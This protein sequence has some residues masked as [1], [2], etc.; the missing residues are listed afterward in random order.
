MKARLVHLNLAT[1]SGDPRMFWLIAS[2][3]KKQNWDVSVACAYFDEKVFPDLRGDIRVSV[4][5]SGKI[6]YYSSG[7]NIYR[8][9]WSRV[10]RKMLSIWHVFLISKQSFDGID[11]LV[12]QN[13]D[14]YILGKI[15][16]RRYP[17]LK[18]VWVMNNAPYFSSSKKNIFVKIGSLI[19]AAVEYIQ[20]RWAISGVDLVVVHDKE[21]EALAKKIT[22]R[23]ELLPIPVEY[24]K[25]FSI[26]R[27]SSDSAKPFLLLSA[28][29]LSPARS[30][31]DVI[32][33]LALLRSKGINVRAEFICKNFWKN[34]SYKNFL[35]KR[36]L[37]G[38]LALGEDVIFHYQ[39]LPDPEFVS[40][41]HRGDAFIFPNRQNIWGMAP[42]EAMAAGMPLLVSASSS[43]AEIVEDG[44]TA[45]I[46]PA[47]DIHKLA[48]LILT[49][50]K[51]PELRFKIAKAGQSFVKENLCWDVYIKK[52]IK[53][54]GV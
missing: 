44:K 37:Q 54:T 39:G 6:S 16:K 7:S 3:L 21:R 22:Q 9:V 53:A 14:S 15:L 28:G 20:A 48:E 17:G 24:D 41:F 34:D 29:S 32:D 27:A 49:L 30:Y 33:A 11:M 23:V 52:F 19:A 2:N 36:V 5:A 47:G 26:P 46:F 50:I 45:L 25:F 1:E 31:E 35:E 4:F 43:V 13:D 12:C 38:G 40:L 18:V 10:T 51:N 8:E 42:M